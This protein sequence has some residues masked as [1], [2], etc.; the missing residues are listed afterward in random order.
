MQLVFWRL[1]KVEA[2]RSSYCPYLDAIRGAEPPLGALISIH[3]KMPA[4][5]CSPH[6]ISIIQSG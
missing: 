1:R 6:S 4:E 3:F 2:D 5:L